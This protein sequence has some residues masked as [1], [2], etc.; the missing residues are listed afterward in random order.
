MRIYFS[1]LSLF[2]P[3]A[4]A[5]ATIP[6]HELRNVVSFIVFEA[7]LSGKWAALGLRSAFTYFNVRLGSSLAGAALILLH[8]RVK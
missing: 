2:P 6:I 5:A 3:L 4:V 7:F 1:P 8:D